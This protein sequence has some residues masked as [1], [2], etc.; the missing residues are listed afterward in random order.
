M[1]H[2]RMASFITRWDERIKVSSKIKRMGKKLTYY[3]STLQINVL[4]TT[5]RF[6]TGITVCVQYYLVMMQ[7]TQHKNLNLRAEG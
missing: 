5:Q 3:A 2:L 7:S 6:Y 1:Y 4:V